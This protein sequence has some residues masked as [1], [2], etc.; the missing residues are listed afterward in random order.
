MH[1]ASVAAMEHKTNVTGSCFSAKPI[2]EMTFKHVRTTG[3]SVQN[4]SAGD[5]ATITLAIIVA[6]SGDVGVAGNERT[7]CF[8]LQGSTSG[9]VKVKAAHVEEIVGTPALMEQ[10]PSNRNLYV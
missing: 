6:K 10:R 4:S 2:S 8:F 7:C 1:P 5:Q 9:W 3:R